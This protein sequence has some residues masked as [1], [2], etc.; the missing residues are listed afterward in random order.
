MRAGIELELVVANFIHLEVAIGVHKVNHVAR[1]E[2]SL[3]H[4]T[5]QNHSTVLVKVSIKHQCFQWCVGIAFGSRQ[6]L[7]DADQYRINVD[8]VL[9]RNR[10]R[11]KGVESQFSV[12]RFL[13]PLDIC[14][15]QIDLVDDRQQCQIVF[16][17]QIQIGHRLRFDSLRRIDND[18]CTF[19]RH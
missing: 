4:A 13:C 7:N 6:R 9:C 11:F 3:H 18:Q 17:C 19:A 8:A 15:R 12:N 10:N 14:G 5:L 16:Q 2:C 1:P